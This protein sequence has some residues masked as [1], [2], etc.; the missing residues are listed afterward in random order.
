MLYYLA[1]STSKSGKPM[2]GKGVY[3]GRGKS[4]ERILRS[5]CE[6]SRRAHEIEDSTPFQLLSIKW[7]LR[8]VSTRHTVRTRCLHPQHHLK[9][10]LASLRI[11]VDKHTHLIHRRTRSENTITHQS[12]PIR[13]PPRLTK[14]LTSSLAQLQDFRCHIRLKNAYAHPNF[15][16]QVTQRWPMAQS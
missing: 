5:Q 8:K 15:L 2:L 13:Y 3:Y 16:V 9:S 7:L 10:A 1:K 4:G 14:H 12:K 11:L 6:T